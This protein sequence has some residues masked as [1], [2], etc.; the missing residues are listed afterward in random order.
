M[1]SQN[2]V[3]LH[4]FISNSCLNVW[5]G[6]FRSRIYHL[7]KLISIIC[8]VLTPAISSNRVASDKIKNTS[9]AHSQHGQDFQINRSDFYINY[10]KKIWKR[11]LWFTTVIVVKYHFYFQWKT[12][13]F[14]P[15]NVIKSIIPADGWS[16]DYNS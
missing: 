8:H 12:L 10:K 1:M 2:N 5:S 13:Y 4:W 7:N 3:I 15:K 11:K 9:Q 16:G 6:I 14:I